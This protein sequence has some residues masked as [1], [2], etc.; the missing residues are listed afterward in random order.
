VGFGRITAGQC[1]IL[2]LY[3][4]GETSNLRPHGAP[5]RTWQ[6]RLRPNRRQHF[7]LRERRRRHDTDGIR[8]EIAAPGC[9]SN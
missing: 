8:L 7:K 9:R 4:P 6:E 3:G 5:K 2:A 1:P